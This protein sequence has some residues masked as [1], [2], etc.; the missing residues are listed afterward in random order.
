MVEQPASPSLAK[1]ITK[2][3]LNA[4]VDGAL[5]PARAAE[6]KAYLDE[7][8]D[9]ARMVAEIEAMNRL[10]RS[11]RAAEAAPLPE[12]LLAAARRLADELGRRS[13]DPAAG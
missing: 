6:V 4:F 10:L 5:S 2:D 11:A 9:A 3:D 12:R 13:E 7:H 1:V 8:A